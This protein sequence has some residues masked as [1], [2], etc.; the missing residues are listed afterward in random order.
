[1]LSV[2]EVQCPHCNAR[3]Q[4]ILPP[5]GSIIVGPCPHCKELVVVF[6]SQVL[7]LSSDLMRYA[8]T[9][10][11]HDHLMDV[12]IEYIDGRVSMIVGEIEG[13]DRMTPEGDSESAPKGD[14]DASADR[15]PDVPDN[16][17]GISQQEIEKFLNTDLR[18]ID[19]PDY[20]HSVFGGK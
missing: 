16:L 12:L 10:E 9:Q 2:I 4:L 17:T 14:S 5:P 11:K 8:S 3:G 18:L 1:M 20:F 6:C 15:G 13:K 19:N 7:P